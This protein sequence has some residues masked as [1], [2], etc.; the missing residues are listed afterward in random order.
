MTGGTARKPS[1]LDTRYCV[2]KNVSPR[3]LRIWLLRELRAYVGTCPA[4]VLRGQSVLGASKFNTAFCSLRRQGRFSG[5]G[6]PYAQQSR[7]KACPNAQIGTFSF[8]DCAPSD[9]ASKPTPSH[10]GRDDVDVA[11]LPEPCPTLRF[12]FHVRCTACLC[13]GNGATCRDNSGR[14]QLHPL[15]SVHSF[16]NKS[17]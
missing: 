9:H 17:A 15:G 2:L 14:A 10:G 11:F 4:P 8:G 6:G 7:W 5:G 3:R 1:V 12:Q 16:A 13:A